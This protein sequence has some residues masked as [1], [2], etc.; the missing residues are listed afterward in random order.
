M[1]LLAE[2]A[3]VSRRVSGTASRPAKI[4]ELA[5]CLRALAPDEIPIAIAFL[6][7]ET[8]QGKIGVA[9]AALRDGN[10]G[11]PPAPPS[12]SVDEVDDAFAG[13]AGARGKGSASARAER[14]SALL[15]RATA[16]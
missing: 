8:R 10:W 6:S 9:Y 13:L 14:L 11:A 4:A 5:A 2:I 12:V 16:E 15:G 1:T 3:A 7:G